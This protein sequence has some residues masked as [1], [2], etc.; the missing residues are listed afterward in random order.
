[1]GLGDSLADGD[2]A[3]FDGG[4]TGLTESEGEGFGAGV[5]EGELEGSLEGASDGVPD[6]MGESL[7][8]G[9][10]ESVG[11]GELVSAGAGD[12]VGGGA[13]FS[14]AITGATVETTTATT[15]SAKKRE[16][17]ILNVSPRRMRDGLTSR[18]EPAREM[19]LRNF[20]SANFTVSAYPDT[21]IN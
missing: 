21:L 16:E 9:V 2:S 10:G 19:R 5:G 13:E 20:S 18:S 14:S 17:R 6:G 12:S 4:A 1:M 11:I 15:A 7:G 8:V 3:A